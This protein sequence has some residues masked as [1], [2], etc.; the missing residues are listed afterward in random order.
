MP[1]GLTSHNAQRQHGAEFESRGD[2]IQSAVSLL[3]SV[4]IVRRGSRA[5]HQALATLFD[6]SAVCGEHWLADLESVW[7]QMGRT[8]RAYPRYVRQHS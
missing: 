4:A 2:R 5:D 1:F 6:A 7:L 8:Q 3:V